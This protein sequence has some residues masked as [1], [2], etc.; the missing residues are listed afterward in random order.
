M[1]TDFFKEIAKNLALKQVGIQEFAESK[2]YCDKRLYPRQ[3]LL[4]KL[5]FLE[6]LTGKEEDILTHWINGGHGGKEVLISPMIRERVEYLRG[7]GFPHFREMVLVGGRRSSKGFIT[8]IAMAKRLYDTLQ[9]HDPGLHYGIDQDKE[10]YFS[11]VASSQDQAKKFQYADLSSTVAR[12]R[13]M[14]DYTTKIQE[15]ELSIA[16]EADRQYLAQAGGVGKRIGR[17]ISKL[18][19]NALAANASTVRGSATMAICFDE[20]AWMLQEGESNQT[21][22]AVYDAVLPS[23][24]QFGKDAMIFCNSS[25]YTK[26]GKFYE[27][28]EDGLRIIDG[29]P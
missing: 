18:R 24:A 15:L 3:L 1:R 20:M 23:L 10:I 17:D 14:N 9:L 25:P 27:R 19:G 12:C 22:A 2:D 21:A 8:G 13:A 6:E 29:K 7:R 28:Y 11:C 16:T 4:L 5:I 26:V